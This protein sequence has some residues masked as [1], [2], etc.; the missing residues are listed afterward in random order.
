MLLKINGMNNLTRFRR[1]TFMN[2][3]ALSWISPWRANVPKFRVF[4]LDVNLTPRVKTTEEGESGTR[5]ASKQ[6]CFRVCTG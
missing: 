5:N 6:R 2:K 3:K 1:L 4:L